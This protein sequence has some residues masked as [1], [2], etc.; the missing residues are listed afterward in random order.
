MTVNL[1]VSLLMGAIAALFAWAGFRTFKRQPPRYVLPAVAGA[2]ILAYTVY[3]DYTWAERTEQ[4]LPKGMVVV[5]KVRVDTLLAPWSY[6]WPMV[7][8]FT[9]VDSAG[10]LRNPAHP[11][12]VL[13]KLYLFSRYQPAHAVPMLMDCTGARMTTVE[14][15]SFLPDGLP[16]DPQWQP[17]DANDP[18]LRAVCVSAASQKAQ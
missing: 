13:F 18:L 8:R 16:T 17:L 1:V 2:A 9:A 11:D 12:W 6:L 4:T 14:G 10:F 3:A 15:A 5:Q 7:Q